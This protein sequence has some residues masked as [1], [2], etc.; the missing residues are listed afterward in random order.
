MGGEDVHEAE[1][2]AA[3]TVG[4]GS[5]N[6]NGNGHEAAAAA[7]S[8]VA[9]GPIYGVLDDEDDDCTSVNQAEVGYGNDEVSPLYDIAATA[10]AAATAAAAAS[11]AAAVGVG[12]G[13]SD[14]HGGSGS[15]GSGGG[16][17]SGDD[18]DAAPSPPP[19][20]PLPP[21]LDLTT[22]STTPR[23]AGANSDDDDDDGGG[24]G[25]LYEELSALD[26]LDL[27]ADQNAA[28]S[29]PLDQSA[30][31]QPNPNH[32]NHVSGHS[33]SVP[34]PLPSSARPRS[35]FSRPVVTGSAL[36]HAATATAAAA[37]AAAVQP[38]P[39]APPA[40]AP[41]AA[42]AAAPAAAPVAA[43][44]EAVQGASY[45]VHGSCISSTDSTPKAAAVRSL[46]PNNPLG[47]PEDD[48]NAPAPPPRQRSWP[49][50]KGVSVQTR[51]RSGKHFENAV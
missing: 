44:A 38:A 13:S 49:L 50:E 22:S 7:A 47:L 25:P 23:D 37:A 32:P 11:A 28:P 19:L 18:G 41:T 14:S 15:S 5:G 42:P 9:D 26:L 30:C 33:R 2:A 36:D 3:E 10:T 12:T 1:R 24:G 29:Q 4:G 8:A 6:G 45:D 48:P 35:T 46:A 51:S 16:G 31:H 39:P 43:A 20:P 21:T 17:G 34:P 40:P 27:H